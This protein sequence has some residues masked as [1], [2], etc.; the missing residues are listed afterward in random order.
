LLLTALTTENFSLPTL[1]YLVSA[2]IPV[3]SEQ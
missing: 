2:I 1:P 3:L